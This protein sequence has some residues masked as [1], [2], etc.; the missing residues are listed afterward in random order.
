M[1]RILLSVVIVL[2]AV[3]GVMAQSG[4]VQGGDD[5]DLR[6]YIEYFVGAGYPGNNPEITIAGLP[7]DF[8]FAFE[9]PIDVNILATMERPNSINTTYEV[10]MTTTADIASIAEA[11]T[12]AF[13]QNGW[14]ELNSSVTRGS[15]FNPYENANGMYCLNDGEIGLNFDAGNRGD[16]KGINL[17]I[18]MP[19]DPYQCIQPGEQPTYIDPAML[20][21]AFTEVPNA[22]VR[23]DAG[24]PSVYGMNMGS[25][26]GVLTVTGAMTDVFAAYSAQLAGAGWT[27]TGEE[28][29]SNQA[30]NQWTFQDVEG[31][32]WFGTFTMFQTSAS[33]QYV[34]LVVVEKAE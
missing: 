15:G 19:A 22:V 1:R 34:A 17:Y 5:A 12:A 2:T 9:L 26:G 6:A 14:V 3:L 7:A 8:P 31:D 20:I 4:V 33:D 24:G 25:S 28:I 10:N 21:P 23:P 29:G 27:Q 32:T 16:I 11:M 18:S 30:R 13:S